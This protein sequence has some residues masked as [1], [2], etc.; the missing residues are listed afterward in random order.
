[1]VARVQAL[2]LEQERVDFRVPFRMDV[3]LLADVGV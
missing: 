3:P 1:M 2:G